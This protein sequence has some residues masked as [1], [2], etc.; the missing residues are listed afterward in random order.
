MRQQRGAPQSG[1]IADLNPKIRGWT[2]YYRNVVAKRSFTRQ[3]AQLYRVLRGWARRRHPRKTKRW[4]FRR[5]WRKVENRTCFTDGQYILAHHA[6]QPIQRHIK[7]RGTKS[8][9]DGDRVYWSARLGRHPAIAPR[10]A[11]LLKQ[12]QGRCVYRRQHEKAQL[13]LSLGCQRYQQ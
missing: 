4:Q 11:R 6:A 9:Y 12:Q 5:Y 3:D 13:D 7:V 1:V 2:L 10:V 8:P